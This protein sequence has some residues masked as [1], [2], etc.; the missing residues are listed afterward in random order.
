MQVTAAIA[1][2]AAHDA[3]AAAHDA[4][5]AAHATAELLHTIFFFSVRKSKR[6]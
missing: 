1:A 4:T 3:T 2:A 6:K 5:A